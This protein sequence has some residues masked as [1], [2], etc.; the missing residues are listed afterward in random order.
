MLEGFTGYLLPW[1]QTAY[2]ATVVGINLNGTAPFLGP[3]LAQF[4]QGGSEIGADT[5]TR[6]YSLHML[7]LPGALFAL[8]GLHLYLVVRLGVTIAAVVAGSA[9]ARARAATPARTPGRRTRRDG[10]AGDGTAA[11]QPRGKR[12]AEPQ[13]RARAEEF[14][15]YKEDVKQRGEAVLPVR[16]VPRHGDVARRRAR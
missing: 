11:R 12:P 2:W 16:D 5:L 8:I 3:F 10:I 15:R 14:E 6:F 13:R 9:R 7:V 4:L 1:D